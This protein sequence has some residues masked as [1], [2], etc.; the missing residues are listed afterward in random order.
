MTRLNRTI[1]VLATAVAA[2]CGGSHKDAKIARSSLYDTDFATVYT[3]ALTATRELYPNL[4]D[5][6]GPGK[7]QTAWH[8]VLLAGNGDD[9]IS[10][11]QT[12]TPGTATTGAGGISPAAGAAGMPT[13]LATK[14]FYIRF[15]VTVVGGR[16]WKVKV[17]GH[18][19]EWSPG[20]ALPVEMHGAN[21]PSWLDP[22]IEQLQVAIYKRIKQFAK[23][24]PDEDKP[25]EEIELP[26]TDPSTFAGVPPAAAKQLAQIKDVL[27]KRDYP[28][29]R[30]LLADDIVWSLGGGTGADAA[31]A[32]WQADPA[33]FDAMAATLTAGCANDGAT[34]VRCP[35]GTV[36]AGQFQLVLESRDAATW[37]V[38]SF[39]KE[40]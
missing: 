35:A 6:P 32:M 31:L 24:A 12:L 37:H 28:G 30:P 25:A 39:L 21:R 7:I 11:V 38:T 20:A 23:A 34:K 8:Q 33:Q 27:A 19:S 29:L 4:D 17:I 13:R 3:A 22:R 14:R 5:S 26:K 10:S 1:F 16:P 18:A 36:T 15:D 2:A 9:D 40:E